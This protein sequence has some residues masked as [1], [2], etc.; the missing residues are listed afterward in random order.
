LDVRDSDLIFRGLAFWQKVVEENEAKL[1]SPL[2]APVSEELSLKMMKFG[3]DECWLYEQT[4]K[5]IIHLTAKL[6]DIG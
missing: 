2:N 5:K 4:R 3:N 1:R 6:T